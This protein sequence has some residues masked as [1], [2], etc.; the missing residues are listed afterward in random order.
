MAALRGARSK[1]LQ[2]AVRNVRRQIPI[3]RR[4]GANQET[5]AY[6][7]HVSTI[8]SNDNHQGRFTQTRL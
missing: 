8:T 5:R 3:I 1:R 4:C 6:R 2:L 7:R